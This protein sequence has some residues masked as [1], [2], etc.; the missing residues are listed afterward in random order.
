MTAVDPTAPEA[1]AAAGRP[2]TEAD[3]ETASSFRFAWRILRADPTAW[4]ISV[5]MWVL[6]F[7]LPLVAGLLLRAVLDHLPPGDGSGIWALVAVL[8]GFEI[9]RWLVLLPAIVQWHGA[10]VFWHTV[11]RINVMR[12]LGQDPGPVT[13][14]LPGSPGEAVSRF[15]DDA[16]DL[17]LVLDVWLDLVAATLGSV[18]GLVVLL[19][20]SPP[21]AAA[22]AVPIVVVL[23]IGQLLAS[24]LRHWRL[25]ERRATAGV[26]GFIGDAFGAIGAVKVAA[27]EPAVLR[28]FEAL[29]HARAAAARRDQVGTQVSQVLGGITA[30]AGLGLALLL[31]APAMRRGDL[32]VGD[33]GLFTTYATVVAGLPRITAR[34]SAWQRQAEVSAARLGRLTVDRDPD[35]AS[36]KVE[37]HLRHGPPP[38]AVDP[39]VPRAQRPAAVR[40]DRLQVRGLR[41]HL[42]DTD[43][44]DG[45]D[46]EV[47]RGQLVVVTGPV[48]SGKS[49]LLRALLG[50]VRAPR[51]PSPGT[52]SGST[53]LRPCSSRRG[54]PTCPRCPG[55][56]PRPSP[57]PSCSASTAPGSPGRSPWPA[58]TTTSTTCPTGSRP[59]SAP[60]ASASRAARCSAPPPL[61]P[62]SAS[63]SCS[64]STTSPAP[65]T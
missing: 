5:S 14:R 62:S 65:S 12:S 20:I 56:S 37:T 57:T 43:Q 64:S 50:L 51:G 15:R 34:W 41:V 44:V 22:M 36:A 45:V 40:L 61:G 39:V 29:G 30:N 58:S 13:G 27:A 16:R 33:I 11:P 49:V 38:Y 48:G 24:R 3:T 9:G 6:F 32:T 23:W 25:D 46:L 54:W 18:G 55:C 42:D 35:A 17:A 53:S 19:L 10:F 21:A 7:C 60:R 31:A 4:L 28:R 63:R 52:A 8:A 47:E 1:A 2:R 59:W 26:T